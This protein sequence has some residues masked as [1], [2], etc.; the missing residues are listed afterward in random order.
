MLLCASFRALESGSTRSRGG[1]L[2][3]ERGTFEVDGAL[4]VGAD[5]LAKAHGTG[6]DS[7]R[8]LCILP[9]SSKKARG[10]SGGVGSSGE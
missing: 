6:Y 2:I 5:M 1:G 10:T 4:V 9:A 3:M 7:P 8:R